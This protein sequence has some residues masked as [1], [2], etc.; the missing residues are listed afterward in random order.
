MT[1]DKTILDEI[2]KIREYIKKENALDIV[3][4]QTY[5]MRQDLD[6]E[7]KSAIGLALVTAAAAGLTY[8][9]AMNISD[10]LPAISRANVLLGALS[11]GMGLIGTPM[12]IKEYFSNKKQIKPYEMALSLEENIK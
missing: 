1:I 10:A 12:K 6:S 4:Y 11:T 3:R 8:A 9:S 5:E 2:N 7:K